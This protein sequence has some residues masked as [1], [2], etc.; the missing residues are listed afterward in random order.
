MNQQN[1]LFLQLFILYILL[2]GGLTILFDYLTGY[3]LDLQTGIPLFLIV[4]A[5]LSFRRSRKMTENG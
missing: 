1:R 2:F 3:E 5:Y 4:A